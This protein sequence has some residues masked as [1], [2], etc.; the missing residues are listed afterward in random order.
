M[1]WHKIFKTE[2]VELNFEDEEQDRVTYTKIFKESKK[3]VNIYLYVIGSVFITYL[4][5]F[6][7]RFSIFDSFLHRYIILLFDSLVWIT[8]VFLIF[9]IFRVFNLKLQSPSFLKHIKDEINSTGLK[10]KRGFRTG[11]FYVVFNSI[12]I[13]IYFLAIFDIIAISIDYYFLLLVNTIFIPI[14][15]G[16]Y[17]DKLTIKLYKYRIRLNFRWRKEEEETILAIH[18]VSSRLCI[19]TDKLGAEI[20]SKISKR[21][22][23]QKRGKYSLS[24]LTPSYHFFEYAWPFNFKKELLNICN[25][26]RD[27]DITYN[28]L[29]HVKKGKL[30]KALEFIDKHINLSP[31]DD[32]LY[33]I[34]C[35]VI[36]D[37]IQK[38]IDV[39]NNITI[40][41]TTFKDSISQISNRKMFET[42]I[43]NL[44]KKNQELIE[45]YSKMLRD[46]SLNS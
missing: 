39:N 25:G 9:S 44:I 24:K 38:K 41:K 35:M 10:I 6:I 32:N 4:I 12:A 19:K 43:W 16:I 5:L 27:W 11:V 37:L 29:K 22:W 21:Y 7:L 1:I 34:K 28:F 30:K 40:F 33:Y 45:I 31:E 26:I 42:K 3:N 2:L 15:L 17:F 20:Y 13:C 18:L 8:V 36:F 46:F 14:I 23:L